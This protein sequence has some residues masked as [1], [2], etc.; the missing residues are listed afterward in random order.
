MVNRWFGS[1]LGIPGIQTTWP[2]TT[3][4]PLAEMDHNCLSYCYGYVILL[5]VWKYWLC[6]LKR[7]IGAAHCSHLSLPVWHKT[8]K[9]FGGIS[10]TLAKNVVLQL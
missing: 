9:T 3:N 8:D 1:G 10:I 7:A 5:I 4:L 6:F 2:Q